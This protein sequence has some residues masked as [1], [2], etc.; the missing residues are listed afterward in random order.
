MAD[1]LQTGFLI[2]IIGIVIVFLVLSLI[3][4]FL[5]L[6]SRLIDS[7]QQGAEMP[8]ASPPN[9]PVPDN[10]D[11]GYVL[12][13]AIAT[14]ER[15]D[16]NCIHVVKYKVV[17]YNELYGQQNKPA[18]EDSGDSA[19][20]KTESESTQIVASKENKAVPGEITGGVCAPMPG[21]ILKIQVSAG[22]QVKKGDVI[23]IL[24]AMKME[25]EIPA[26][27]DGV[28]SDVFAAEGQSVK[29][30]DAIVSIK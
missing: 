19:N 27:S 13:K 9:A 3:W 10:P 23:C 18:E 12:K 5:E 11:I 28:I 29:A 7:R 21:K 25:N 20:N 24:E 8:A 30:G 17:G 4:L 16:E 15:L 2:S 1:I 6:V 22:Q 26:P 14:H